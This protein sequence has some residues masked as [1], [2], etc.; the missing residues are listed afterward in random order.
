MKPPQIILIGFKNAGKSTIGNLLA[1]KV[2]RPFVD[3]DEEILIEHQKKTGEKMSCREIMKKHGDKFFRDLEH[4]V[5]A[6]IMVS[7]GLMVLA[8][9][10]GTPLVKENQDLFEDQL[11]IHIT[12]P[13]S[14]IFER[15]MIN[16]RPAFFPKEQDSFISFQ[17]LWKERDPVFNRLANI[18]VENS[19]SVEEAVENI[20]KKIG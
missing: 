2:Q 15:I 16:G 10:G 1:K 5:L 8:V 18:T 7:K 12:A 13:K 9:G 19:G 6:N 14:I 3:L 17:E 20:I 11:V 4:E